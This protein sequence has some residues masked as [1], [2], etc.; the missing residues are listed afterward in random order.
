M[1]NHCL[2][3]SLSFRFGTDGRTDAA[4][5]SSLPAN[6]LTHNNRHIQGR[7]GG[8]RMRQCDAMQG[9]RASTFIHCQSAYPK[10]KR[11]FRQGYPVWCSGMQCSNLQGDGGSTDPPTDL[12]CTTTPALLLYPSRSSVSRSRLLPATIYNFS[13]VSSLRSY[14]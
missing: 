10:G 6:A 7:G 8:S 5:A 2:G 14:Y 4:M 13:T 11:T 1:S 9:V 12:Q 3:P